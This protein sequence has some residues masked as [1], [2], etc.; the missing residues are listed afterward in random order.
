MVEIAFVVTNQ[1]TD[2]PLSNSPPIVPQP[3]PS[4][5]GS[6]EPTPAEGHALIKAFV[7]IKNPQ[8]RQNILAFVEKTAAGEVGR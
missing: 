7:K 2:T 8:L 3:M 5:E 6:Q 1:L 4:N